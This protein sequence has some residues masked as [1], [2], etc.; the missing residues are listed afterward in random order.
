M[1]SGTI[2]AGLQIYIYSIITPFHQNREKKTCGNFTADRNERHPLKTHK[3]VIVSS[4]FKICQ[5][6]QTV[7]NYVLQCTNYVIH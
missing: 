6:T 5:E 1:N 2:S 3:I 7:L 4:G